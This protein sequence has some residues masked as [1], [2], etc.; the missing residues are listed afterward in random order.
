MPITSIKVN[1]DLYFG[2][3]QS[4]VGITIRGMLG[5]FGGG[6]HCTNASSI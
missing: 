1:G 4:L 6:L 3:T 5:Y 2:Y